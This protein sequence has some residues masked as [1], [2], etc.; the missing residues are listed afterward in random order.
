MTQFCE[1]EFSVKTRPYSCCKRQG[2][3]RFSCFQEGAPRPHYQL[4]TCPSHQPGISMGLEVP[5]PPGLPTLDNVKNICHLRRLRSVPRN[6][7]ATDP[8]QRQLHTLTQLEAEFQ[9]CCRQGSNH[10]CALKAVS[11]HPSLPVS[12][13]SPPVQASMCLPAVRTSTSVCL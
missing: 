10:T 3:A 8:I 7:P 4:R 2:E 9:H 12:D 5:F 13:L 11:E 6:L 1:A